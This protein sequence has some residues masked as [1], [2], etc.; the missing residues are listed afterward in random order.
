ML[1]VGNASNE[2][3][4]LSLWSGH[5]GMWCWPSLW[6]SRRS[7][8][9]S[10]QEVTV[11]LWEEWPTSTSKSP[12]LMHPPTGEILQMSSL[13][14]FLLI[15]NILKSTKSRPPLISCY[16]HI[17]FISNSNFEQTWIHHLPFL[18]LQVAYISHMFQP[19]LP[20]TIQKQKRTEA[21]VNYCHFKC[22]GI[23]TGV[24]SDNDNG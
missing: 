23:W 5:S 12:R 17:W 21:E 15:V 8:C 18:P 19:D 14:S 7:C 9:I 4:C 20:A 11:S 16:C 13:C 22:G 2:L 24:N 10:Q 3:N 1:S 6:S